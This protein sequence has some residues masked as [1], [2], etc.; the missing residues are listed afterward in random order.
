MWRAAFLPWPTATVTVRSAGTMSPPAKMPGW[1]VIM[2]GSTTTVPSDLN[3]MPGTV[4]RKPLSLSWPSASTTASASSVSNSP[5]GCGR[6]LSSSVIRSTVSVG[7]TISL[8]RGQPLDLDAFLDRL[9]GLEAM[10]RH[11]GAVA[12]IDDQRLV[13]AE[14]AA[15]RAASIAV[16]PP[17]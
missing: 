3:A 11:V 17:P 5:V 10:R 12:A 9:V 8:M 4:R 14:A 1:P 13:G 6:P 2:S 7:P 16:L 15:V